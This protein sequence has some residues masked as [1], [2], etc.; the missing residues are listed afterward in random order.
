MNPNP[1]TGKRPNT[2][3]AADNVWAIWRRLLLVLS[4]DPVATVTSPAAAVHLADETL[5]LIAVGRPAA[6]PAPEVSVVASAAR[7]LPRRPPP[8]DAHVW[9]GIA[10]EPLA[11]LLC[12]ASPIGYGHGI[13]WVHDTAARLDSA[14]PDDP[15]WDSALQST[16]RGAR[17]LRNALADLRELEP[18]PRRAITHVM[19]GAAER[20][21][22]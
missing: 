8:F 4:R 21:H 3:T 6:V 13:E 5:T 12:A 7:G 16:T 2:P 15:I 9:T 14:D 19:L 10:I 22:R 20:L 1:P 11:A 17:H 18:R